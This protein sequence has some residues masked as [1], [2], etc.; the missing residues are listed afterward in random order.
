[1]AVSPLD[2]DRSRA[3]ER[4]AVAVHGAERQRAVAFAEAVEDDAVGGLDAGLDVLQIDRSPGGRGTERSV[5]GDDE[6][7]G[8]DRGAPGIG[9]GAAQ[10]D[11]S[12]V[13]GA[14]LHDEAGIRRAD[15]D[16][17][18]GSAGIQRGDPGKA[19]IAVER[20]TRQRRIADDAAYDEI[21]RQDEAR[22]LRRGHGAGNV[23]QR[24]LTGCR[25]IPFGGDGDVARRQIGQ[26][27]TVIGVAIGG[28]LQEVRIETGHL[29]ETRYRRANRAGD[30]AGR[31]EQ[32][33]ALVL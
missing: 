7:A 11:G 17:R 28:S 26:T 18:S 30:I 8:Q 13:V 15:R 1:M 31:G 2:R 19:A 14:E 29:V 5:A 6:G 27:E 21:A 9:I 4:R 3:R 32:L 20:A 12:A 16:R 10:G 24:G 33:A 22:Q 23:G 25:L